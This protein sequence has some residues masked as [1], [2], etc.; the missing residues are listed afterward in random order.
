[1]KAGKVIDTCWISTIKTP[2]IAQQAVRLTVRLEETSAFKVGQTDKSAA[3]IYISNVLM[4]PGWWTERVTDSYL[5][6]YSDKKYRLF[7]E[8]TGEAEIDS[9]NIPELRDYTLMLKNYLQK[10]KDAGRTVYEENGKE[11]TV[12]YFGG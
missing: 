11:M 9:S 8:V 5:G 7:I 4:K 12:E 10:E 1:M 3:I 6:E 2:Q